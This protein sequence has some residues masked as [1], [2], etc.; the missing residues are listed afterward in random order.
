L[1]Y[2]RENNKVKTGVV[3]RPVSEKGK[4]GGSPSQHPRERIETELACPRKGDCAGETSSQRRDSPLQRKRDV[5]LSVS[6]KV[7]RFEIGAS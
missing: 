5:T 3:G 4:P 7:Y 1:C 6:R 2:N